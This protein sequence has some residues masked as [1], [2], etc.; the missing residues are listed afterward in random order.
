[1]SV[2]RTLLRLWRGSAVAVDA[3]TL[4]RLVDAADTLQR[5]LAHLDVEISSL[6][7]RLHDQGARVD[8]MAGIRAAE[9]AD[10]AALAAL[11]EA[12]LPAGGIV[13]RGAPSRRLGALRHPVGLPV[14]YPLAPAI[15]VTA[16]ETRSADVRALWEGLLA[17]EAACA[18]GVLRGVPGRVLEVRDAIVS[19][20]RRLSVTLDA[21]SAAAVPIAA[22]P[23]FT[24]D[25]PERK[26]RNVG[27]WLLDCLPQVLA[28]MALAP[29]ATLVLPPLPK[30]VHWSLL[31]LIGVNRQ[32][33]LEWDGSRL[34]CS[35]LFVMEADGRLARGRPLPL[36]PELRRRFAAAG[37]SRPGRR[38]YV[39]RRDAD[40]RRRWVANDAEVE[41]LFRARGFEVLVMAECT[42]A[43]QAR[44]FREAA[45]VAGVSGAGLAD[46]VFSA[47]G[48]QVIAL[49]TDSLM[50]WYAA[51]SGS[52]SD[53]IDGRH[54]RAGVPLSALS[55]SPRFYA[56]L[57]AA[58]GQRCHSFVGED[59][60]PA[61]RLNAFLDRVLDEGGRD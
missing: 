61:D 44:L 25:F 13:L 38:L 56:H 32:R 1:M 49:L 21:V 3:A 47:P 29:E 27:H 54:V 53:W 7:Q 60:L 8:A 9:I 24:F 45:I 23:R 33:V 36:L 4:E 11:P 39:S 2:A 14:A 15:G 16:C 52:R 35:R 10:L 46:L 22:V 12:R 28:V 50:R 30:P 20:E 6:A 37:D 31:E 48:T 34:E 42:P 5:D 58:C 18:D 43:E 57:A 51:D 55:D 17:A 41:A 26:L 59:A 19:R 40:A